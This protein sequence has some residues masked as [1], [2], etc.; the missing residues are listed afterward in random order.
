M[1]HENAEIVRKPLWVRERSSRT[2]D[3][4]LAAQ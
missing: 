3:G 2:L 4:R 1:S